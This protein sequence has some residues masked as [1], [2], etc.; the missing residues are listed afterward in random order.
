MLPESYGSVIFE[1]LNRL[2]LPAGKQTLKKTKKE[3]KKN[4]NVVEMSTY[5]VAF[6]CYL[7]VI[8]LKHVIVLHSSSYG[9]ACV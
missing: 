1:L 2:W 7:R 3:R 8:M 9:F 6:G 5:T 4:R